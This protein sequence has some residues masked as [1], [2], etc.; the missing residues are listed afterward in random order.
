VPK[1]DVTICKIDTGMNVIQSLHDYIGLRHHLDK[2]I[3]TK[4]IRYSKYLISLIQTINKKTKRNVS[5][6]NGPNYKTEKTPCW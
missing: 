5:I 6:E 2:I 4:E 3:Q 1:F